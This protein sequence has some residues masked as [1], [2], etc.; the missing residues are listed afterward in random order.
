MNAMT[1]REDGQQAALASAPHSEPTVSRALRLSILRFQDRTDTDAA[2]SITP[3]VQSEAEAA[4]ARYE[5]FLSPATDIQIATWLGEVN[6]GTRIPLEKSTLG[7]KVKILK[8]DL[9]HL[10]GA[11]FSRETRLAV[12][13]RVPY[14]PGLG[15]ILA[16]C[17]P[18]AEEW[19][20]KVAALRRIA[21]GGAHRGSRRGPSAEMTIA[22]VPTPEE[23]RLALERAEASKVAVAAKLKSFRA[24]MQ[25]VDEAMMPRA[26]RVP[27]RR[28]TPQEEIAT[29]ERD[30]AEGKDRTGSL[31]LL[32]RAHRERAGENGGAQ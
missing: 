14:F 16:V 32:L 25:R 30:I 15:D 4:V 26:Q 29:L 31:A 22:E 12:A 7:T 20:R 10:P 23:Q 17:E 1:I 27:S 18:V 24:E 13:Q 5:R 9:C 21:G 8:G 3:A 28:L 6:G 2:S 19:R 11:C